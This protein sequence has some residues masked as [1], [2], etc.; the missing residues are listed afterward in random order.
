M[1][2]KNVNEKPIRVF[3]DATTLIKVGAPPGNET[4]QRLVDLV[5]YGFIDVVVTDLTKLEIVRHHS[6]VASDR[7]QPLVDPRFRRLAARHL[8]VE[9]P[10]INEKDVRDKV[11]RDIADGVEMMFSSLKAVVLYVNDVRP[12][13][14][15]ADF[16]QNEG[17]FVADNKKYQF[18]DAFIFECLKSAATED[19]PL[20]LVTDDRDFREPAN[21]TN[22]I[23]VV[24]SISELFGELGLLVEEPDP[25]LEPFLYHDLLENTDFLHYVESDAWQFD[26]YEIE[27]TCTTIDFNS[28]TAFQQVNENAP[29][30]ISVEVTVDL[31][32]SIMRYDWVSP[33]R[34]SGSAQVSFYASIITDGAGE[35]NGVADLR[36]FDCSLDFGVISTSFIF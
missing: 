13:V 33:E 17:F 2:M 31:D 3:F 8:D 14:I 10:D 27:T 24:S 5:E 32:V 16:D 23:R 11:K 30:L 4:F 25:D 1:L 34:N 35:P 15:F 18:P 26:E 9:L 29:L 19:A 22:H 6:N 7:L 28:I 12:S 36:V 20:L 21:R